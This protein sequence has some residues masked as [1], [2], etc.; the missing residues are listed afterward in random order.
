ML[1]IRRMSA[2]PSCKSRE[3]A[4]M[5]FAQVQYV[6][7]SGTQDAERSSFRKF[8]WHSPCVA[9]VMHA[10]N[11]VVTLAA[12]GSRPGHES[13]SRAAMAQRLA[14][15]LGYGF[16]GDYDHDARY[17]GQVY[18]VPQ[19]TLLREEAEQLGIRSEAD[20]YGGVVPDQ[21]VATKAI[22]H[23]AIDADAHVPPAWAHHLAGHLRGVVLPGY[24]AFDASDLRHAAM[25]L[26]PHGCIR[27]K[28]AHGIGGSHQWTAL[29]ESGLDDI[30]ERLDLNDLHAHGA[31]VEQNYEFAQTYSIGEVV[32]AD[33]RIAYHGLQRLTRNHDGAEVYGG[34]DLHIVRGR[35][36]D[37]LPLNLPPA[38][39]IAIGQA[40]QYD[41][42]VNT[43]FPDF[44]ASRRN[45]DVLQGVDRD[46]H[47]IS[48]VLEQSW[49]IGGASPSE[50]AAIEAFKAHPD[51]HS[52]NACNY[53]V[54]AQDA[55]MPPHASVLFHGRDE[56]V[57]W[58]LKYS[59]IEPADSPE[60]RPH[61]VVG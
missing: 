50:I 43:V 58:L 17:A 60:I 3:M 10:G 52:A 2:W 15:I 8:Q 34:S 47:F 36:S 57:G 20:L 42:A 13:A 46:G 37:L 6:G 26:L 30:I 11:V 38:V 55:P 31:V 39:K 51:M 24:S 35:F 7:T 32:V 48:G 61:T 44:F 12:P 4:R 18:F 22:T 40:M 5:P 45:Y 14:A 53:E 56:R 59:V 19:H 28:G 1:A 23:P 21:F 41:A 54:Y 27:I 16:A 25:R 49:R 29:D 33:I 9:M